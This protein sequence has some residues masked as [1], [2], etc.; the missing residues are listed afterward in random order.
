MG[1][2]AVIVSQNTE[3]VS[4]FKTAMNN[5]QLYNQGINTNTS[6]GIRLGSNKVAVQAGLQSPI[7]GIGHTGYVEYKNKQVAMGHFGKELLS[8]DNTHN[9]YLDAFAR[10]GAIGLIA[11]ILFLCFPIYVGIKVWKTGNKETLPYAAAITT[12]GVTFAIANISQEVIYLS[13][14]A[15]MYTGLL[16]ILTNMLCKERQS[17]VQ[18]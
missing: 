14:G 11:V 18:C 12:F 15:I 7:F 4:R 16:I 3:T 8:F 13:T 2:S 1:I 10:R 17:R 5:L 9:T 6:T